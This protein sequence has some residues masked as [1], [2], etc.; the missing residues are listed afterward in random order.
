MT[1]RLILNEAHHALVCLN[2]GYKQ[3]EPGKRVTEVDGT[4]VTGLICRH[5]GAEHIDDESSG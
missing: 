3:L 4:R 5:C 2:C 1:L